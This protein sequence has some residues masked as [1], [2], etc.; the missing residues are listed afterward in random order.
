MKTVQLRS[1]T[2]K[3]LA[4]KLEE[5]KA[6]LFNLRF[7]HATGSLANPLSL[8]SCKKN[9]AQ[10]KTIIRERELGIKASVTVS[11]K[12]EPKKAE[13]KKE[14]KKPA[15]KSEEKTEATK[16]TKKPAATK[17]VAVKKA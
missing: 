4:K 15:K 13:V 12:A 14:A 9:I 17:K 5:L 6:E 10:I 8:N 1:M 16:A 3:E 7:S 2:D 11:A